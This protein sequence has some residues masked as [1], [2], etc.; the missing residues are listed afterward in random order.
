MITTPDQ[1]VLVI[2]YTPYRRFTLLLAHPMYS[3]TSLTVVGNI[4]MI[5][6]MKIAGK[7][8][9]AIQDV[10]KKGCCKNVVRNK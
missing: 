9:H 10:K 1:I 7:R 3:P 8:A 6:T 5:V 2:L 4:Y